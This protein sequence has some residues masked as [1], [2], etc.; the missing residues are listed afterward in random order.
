MRAL[1]DNLDDR[2][3]FVGKNETTLRRGDVLVDFT[4]REDILKNVKPIYLTAPGWMQDTTELKSVADMSGR[5]TSYLDFIEECTGTP[6]LMASVSPERNKTL[7]Y[8]R[9]SLEKMAS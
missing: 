9:K 8:N 1:F 5:M 4:P 6:V 2:Y 3:C 7:I